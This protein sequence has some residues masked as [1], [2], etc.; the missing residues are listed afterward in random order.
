MIYRHYKGAATYYGMA[1]RREKGKCLVLYSPVS[2]GKT[3]AS[4][5]WGFLET[6]SW[7]A[8]PSPGSRRRK[9]AP[10]LRIQRSR[11]RQ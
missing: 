10:S 11:Q 6:S 7:R 1:T 9:N 8:S 5:E 3:W 4:P 2:E